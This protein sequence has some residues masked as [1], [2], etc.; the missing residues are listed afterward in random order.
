MRSRTARAL[1]VLLLALLAAAPAHAQFGPPGPVPVGVVS[2]ERRPVTQSVEFTGR[3]QSTDKVEIVPRVTAFLEEIHF[4]EGADVQKGDLLYV[5]ERGPFEADVAAKQAAVAQQQALLKN[6]TIAL[7][8]AQSLLNTVA[9]QRSTVDDALA[10]QASLTAVVQSAQAQL[11]QSQINLDYTEIH[12]PVSGHISRSNIT[13]GNVV[14]P[15]SGALATIY[16]QDPMYVLF[17]VSVRVALELRDRYAARGTWSGARVRLK[18]SDGTTYGQVGT[19]DYVDP[20]VGTNTDTLVLRARIPNP[21][22]SGLKASDPDN[23]ELIDGEFVTVILEGAEPVMA[24][25]IPRSAVL[26][27][28]QGTYVYIVG[29]KNIAEQRRVALGP[30]SGVMASVLSG[31]QEGDQVIVDGLQKLHP[32]SQVA[33]APNAAGPQGA[34]QGAPPAAPGA[35][36]ASGSNAAPAGGGAAEVG[37]NSGGGAGGAPAKKAD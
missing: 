21:V 32:G 3:I 30:S 33:P 19:M 34:P 37:S 18:L 36:P 8:R 31:L 17:P 28:Q 20:T 15:S 25:A 5:L 6:A 7:G 12:A 1:P 24:L 10:Q 26:L 35:A 9:G 13:V 23:R 16:S 29:A 14:S 11:R 2:A 4:V 27:D 22:R